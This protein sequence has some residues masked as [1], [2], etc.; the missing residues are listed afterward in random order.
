[1]PL[2]RLQ[3]RVNELLRFES[4]EGLPPALQ[5]LL[6]VCLA[7]LILTGLAAGLMAV[8]TSEANT[9]VA[10]TI[11]ARQLVRDVLGL[12]EDAELGQR[13]FLLTEDPK[14]LQDYA[15]AKEALPAALAKLGDQTADNPIQRGRLSQLELVLQNRLDVI[16][17]TIALAKESRRNE[18]V[19]LVKTGTGKRL[20][21]EVKA[22]VAEFMQAE[23]TLLGERQ[24]NAD[25]LRRWLL[26]LIGLSLASATVLG[27]LVLQSARHYIGLL[28]RRTAELEAE[29]SRRRETED[30]LR[31]VQKIEA[32]GQ[33]SGGI[34]HDFNNLLTIIMGNLDTIAR[35]MSKATD[36]GSS[37]L[38][39]EIKRPVELA[40]QGAKS[41]AHLTQRLLAFSRRQTLDP[42]RVDINKLVAGMSE[43]LRRTLSE[44]INFETVLAGGLW[45]TLVDANQLENAI[46]NLAVNA[47]D[48]MPEGGSLTIE[49]ANT[50]LDEA[51]T[52]HFGDVEPGQYVMLS[53]TDTG[54]GIS[55]E[56][57]KRIFEPFFTT[58]ETGKGS[59]LGLAMVHGFVKQSGGHLR[60]YSEPGEGTTVKIYLPRLAESEKVA[61]APSPA[62]VP[63]GVAARAR[64]GE[65]ILVVE[66]NDSV[67]EYASGALKELGYTVVEAV[68]GPAALEFL[69]GEA[70]IALLFTDV[71][72]PGGISGRE[73][74][75]RFSAK[76]PDLPVL[77]TTGYT[78]NAIVHHGRLDPTVHLLNKPYTQQDLG[79]KVRQLLDGEPT[80]GGR[81]AA[82]RAN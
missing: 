9:W 17:E 33:L 21:D 16:D 3:A 38:A 50:Y 68:D 56:V 7:L 48:A 65:T 66:D 81:P 27:F 60:V 1:M 10:H 34:A 12:A 61:S 74:A 29:A 25:T 18:A 58:K 8:R 28:H 39:D 32:V 53:V 82:R 76:M 6:V 63:R 47:R 19:A 24:L 40:M 54:T 11:E 52:S 31:Q 23:L 36:R 71:V 77:F 22:R 30:T 49:T 72:L 55:P 78:R 2:A 80:T 37:A 62:Q 41:A 70:R 64:E 75:N 42:V 46:I 15:A 20:M 35:R 59:G 67:R 5:A 44:S 4:R 14:Y 73:L 45:P 51:Y 57:M 43:L 79:R 13:G 69:D 26:F